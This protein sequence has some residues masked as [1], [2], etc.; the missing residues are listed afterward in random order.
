MTN[1]LQEGVSSLLRCKISGPLRQ[2]DEELWCAMTSEDYNPRMV[3]TLLFLTL[4]TSGLFAGAALYL[5]AVEHP[6]RTSQGV[7]IALQEFRPTYNRAAPLQAALAV[8]CFLCSLIA[9]RPRS[10]P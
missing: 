2:R 9:T 6:A 7:S 10:R 4:S 8:I 1:H 5:A 3:S